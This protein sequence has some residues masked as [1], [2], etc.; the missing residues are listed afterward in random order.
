MDLTVVVEI[1]KVGLSGLVFLLAFMGYRLLQREQKKQTPSD[2]SL[3]SIQMFVWQAI[4]LAILVGGVTIGLKIIDNNRTLTV[5]TSLETCRDSLSDLETIR[6]LEKLSSEDLRDAVN[7][8]I[9]KCKEPL[10]VLDEL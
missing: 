2:K 1:L 10:E 5:L 9:N 3:R 4:V 8:H 7:G 6:H